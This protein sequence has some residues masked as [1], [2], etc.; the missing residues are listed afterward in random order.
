MTSGRGCALPARSRCK[1]PADHAPGRARNGDS[2]C[3]YATA[4]MGAAHL[5]GRHPGAGVAVVQ[6]SP[7]VRR[8]LR[9]PQ[10]AA[11]PRHARPGDARPERLLRGL[12]TPARLGGGDPVARPWALLPNVAPWGQRARGSTAT[13]T[14]RPNASTATATTTTGFT[15]FS[16]PLRWLAS[17]GDNIRPTIREGQVSRGVSPG[18]NETM[19]PMRSPTRTAAETHGVAAACGGKRRGGP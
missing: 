7:G 15:T 2:P 17:G 5:E 4:A 13:G 10:R 8:G 11:D 9:A 14:A 3:A 16:S 6:P 19:K 12:P 18:C 1:R